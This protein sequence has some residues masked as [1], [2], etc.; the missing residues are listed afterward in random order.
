MT[1]Q[2]DEVIDADEV[3]TDTEAIELTITVENESENSYAIG[4]GTYYKGEYVGLSAIAA[5]NET[6]L[7]W[8]MNGELISSE[9]SYRFRP[10]ADCTI[11]AKWEV[12]ETEEFTLGDVNADGQITSADARTTLR[13]AVGLD[14]LTESQKKAADADKNGEITSADARLILRASVGLENLE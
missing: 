13:A 6:F 9:E 1:N 11:V 7:G 8:Y 5:E 2:E 14:E 12:A 10:D 3:L 4:G